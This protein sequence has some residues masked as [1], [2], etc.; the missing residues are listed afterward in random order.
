MSEKILRQK[1]WT[2]REEI[3]RSE[4]LQT[5]RRCP[6]PDDE[7]LSHLGLFVS[8]R[9]LSRILLMDFLYR[10][11]L[12]IHGNIMEFGVRWGQNLA[13]FSTLRGIYE[14]F[15]RHRKVIG[16]DTFEGLSGVTEKDGHAEFIEPGSLAVTEGYERYLEEVLNFH[17]NENPIAHFKKFD[18]RKGDAAIQLQKY[19]DEHP[20]TIVAL[21]FFDMG[22]YKPTRE[23]LQ[24]IKD[25]LTKGSILAFDEL[26]EPDAP[27]ETVAVKEVFG[28][29]RYS[30]QRYPFASRVSYIIIE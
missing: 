21:A 15:N 12:R 23:C 13:L 30:I 9:N 22:L 18:I 28:L 5:F 8:S 19:L 27:G 7:L 2:E 4:F 29:G 11:V 14:P 17:E 24:I 20:E 16:F 25:H 10:Q 26:N 6:I 3:L 1:T